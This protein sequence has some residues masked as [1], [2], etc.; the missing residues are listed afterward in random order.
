MSEQN[1][2]PAL[3]YHPE[4]MAAAIKLFRTKR[5]PTYEPGEDDHER[6]IATANL[7][8]RFSLPP[9]VVQPKCA[10]D[11]RDVV[12]IAKARNIP[13]TIKNG[14]HSFAGG[15]TAQV[16]ILMEL[17]LM[18]Q[19]SIAT[20]EKTGEKTATIKGGALWFHVY[21][22]LISE[23]LDG[24]VV[25]G[26]RCPSVGVSGFILG[27]GLAPF[28]RSFGMGCDT[29]K[30][31]S[32]VTAAGDE[33]TVTRNDSDPNKR[34]L[35]WALR[36]AGGGN[37]GVVTE[38]KLELKKLQSNWVMAGKF[39]W[40]V[41]KENMDA[42]MITMKS[43][44]SKNWP[45]AMT[46]DSTWLCETSKTDTE[47]GVRFI[48]YFNGRK[49]EYEEVIDGWEL[50]KGDLETLT[51]AQRENAL[52]QHDYLKTQLK[53]RSLEEVSTRFLHETLAAQWIEETKKAFPTNKT[54]QLHT[55]FVFKNNAEIF[56]KIINILRKEMQTFRE[57]FGSEKDTVFQATFI[58][59]GGEANVRSRKDSAFRWRG[60][61]YNAYINLEFTDKWLEYDMR[62]VLDVM[63]PQLRP[64]G[65]VPGATYVNFPDDRLIQH[66]MAYWGNNIWELR[67]VKQIWDKDGYFSWAQ[68]IT[69]PKTKVGNGAQQKASEKLLEKEG[70]DFIKDEMDADEFIEPEVN[71]TDSIARQQW[72][73]YQFLAPVEAYGSSILPALVASQ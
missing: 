28:T 14:G 21:K 5:I 64:Y 73:T 69:V 10:C 45:N 59:S 38:M 7:L 25:N 2:I 3:P 6:Y 46:I 50:L 37:F 40:Y 27:G 54:Y 32:I 48:V 33:V 63:K 72:E 47:V 57:K 35:F 22:K 26:G 17:G 4:D 39:T 24:L 23:R 68:G 18:N 41:K 1:S 19:V 44:Y 67:R 55:S 12:K 34:A 52:T 49:K 8:Y 9:C 71:S 30:E 13:I 43:F 70:Q 20:D 53:Q 29:V 65:M 66:E 56:G 61:T 60:S 15:S 16:G 11:V 62:A 36:G 42:F 31:F 51:E 58:H